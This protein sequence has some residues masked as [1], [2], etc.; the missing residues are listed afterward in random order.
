MQSETI[1]Q[2][3]SDL[4]L[5]RSDRPG[6][7]WSNTCRAWCEEVV[8]T[9][10]GETYVLDHE[11]VDG[12]RIPYSILE[13]KVVKAYPIRCSDCDRESKRIRRLMNLKDLVIREHDKLDRPYVGMLTL[14][15]RGWHDSYYRNAHPDDLVEIIKLARKELYSRW[16]LF[17]RNY[18]KKHCV[19]AIRFFEWTERTDVVQHHVDDSDPTTVS[20]KLHP[21]LHIFIL[22]E[23]RSID[24]PE[25][26][27]KALA[28]GFGDQIDMQWKP[29]A[30]TFSSINYCLSYVKKDLQVD[31]RNKQT[32]G[33]FYR[34]SE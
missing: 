11:L 30:S 7:I 13:Q 2:L 6:E 16:I 22:Q 23:G 26:R 27:S 19:G 17:W 31:G 8:H 10:P 12:E 14:N 29:N 25:L 28:A 20:M 33:C 21:H 32:Y 1:I 18:L 24:I 4:P 15:L 9:E 5:P 3:G 34:S